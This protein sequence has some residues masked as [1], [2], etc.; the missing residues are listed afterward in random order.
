MSGPASFVPADTPLGSAEW[1]SGCQINAG[2]MGLHN[3]LM[4][5]QMFLPIHLR[6]VQDKVP[7]VEHVTFENFVQEFNLSDRQQ[8]TDTYTALIGSDE[9]R[10][11][12]RKRLQETFNDF[13]A[14][15]ED[16][17]W[18]RRKLQ[19]SSEITSN[20]AAVDLQEAA[21]K[22]A[23]H[24][25]SELSSRSRSASVEAL[26]KDQYLASHQLAEATPTSKRRQADMLQGGVH[27][28]DYSQQKRKRQQQYKKDEDLWAQRFFDPAAVIPSTLMI[29]DIGIGLPFMRLQEEAAAI[30]NDVKKTL[31]P[32][33]LPFFLSVNHIWDSHYRLPGIS[34]NDHDAIQDAL[35]VPVVRLPDQLVFFCRSLEHDLTSTGYIRS[36]ETKSRDQDAL[37]VLYQQASQK[38]P[39]RFLSFEHVKNEDTHA[40]S[41][42]DTL[43]TFMFPTYNYRY[44]LHWANRPTAGSG[45]RR[46]G[47]AFKPD[48]QVIK[49][50]FEL[51]YM[52]IKPPKEERHQRA[53]LEDVWALSGLAKDSIDL[54]LRHGRIITTIPCVLVFGFQMTL[55]QLSFQA[56]IY[57][58]QTIHTSYLPRDHYDIGNVVACVELLKTFK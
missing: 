7:G 44:E 45:D 13:K 21:V 32:T 25:Y 5:Y 4:R 39:K 6:W 43:F 52:E 31:T 47:D 46:D 29:K 12:R 34:D 42:L 2:R 41:V 33:L 51:G 28:Q 58:W 36:R 35:R 49:D 1:G 11:H 26:E 24:G 20:D 8:A 16:V 38:L 22:K 19:I 40:H 9:I 17:F 15:Y 3:K 48:A 18:S 56:G 50:G 53:Y 30:V 14:H 57:L 55:F 23:R 37:L 27:E 54:H 10:T